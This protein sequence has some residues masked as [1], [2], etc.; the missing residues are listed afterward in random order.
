MG[1]DIEAQEKVKVV[2]WDVKHEI[3]QKN[4]DAKNRA[5]NCLINGIPFVPTPEETMYA[6][7]GFSVTTYNDELP[8]HPE[9]YEFKE[10]DCLGHSNV[11][12]KMRGWIFH[13]DHPLGFIGRPCPVCG[14]KYGT[15]WIKE[16]VPEEVVEWLYNLPDS[17]REPAWI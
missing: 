13:R 14:Y 15:S 11:E 10:K 9:F 6:N 2:K 17:K 3:F 8:K 12:Y 1:W 5:I 4:E 7:A 16:E